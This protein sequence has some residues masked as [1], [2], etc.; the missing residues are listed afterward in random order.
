MFVHH[1]PKS[2]TVVCCHWRELCGFV[3]GDDFIT[4]DSVQLMWIESRLF[5]GLNFER[6]AH[7]GVNDGADKT[8][9]ILNRLVTWVC[10]SGSRNQAA[11]QPRGRIG[12]LIV[13]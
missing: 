12:L 1:K 3:H 9:T 2:S 4:G 5:E 10:L 6:C 13:L 11:V 7:L 8:V